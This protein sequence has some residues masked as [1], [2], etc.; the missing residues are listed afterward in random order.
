MPE[1]SDA[2]SVPPQPPYVPPRIVEVCGECYERLD[3]GHDAR[4]ACPGCW[5]EWAFDLLDQPG[6]LLYLIHGRN[7]EWGVVVREFSAHLRRR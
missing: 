5:L 7:R 3:G 4:A 6:E 1:P 2:P